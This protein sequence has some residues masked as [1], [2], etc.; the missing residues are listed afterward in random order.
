VVP[1]SERQSLLPY[2]WASKRD[3]RSGRLAFEIKRSSRPTERLDVGH[4]AGVPRRADCDGALRTCHKRGG[5]VD[6][7]RPLTTRSTLMVA[8]VPLDAWSAIIHRVN[9]GDDESLRHLIEQ[10]IPNVTVVPVKG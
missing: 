7:G 1:V 6:G 5:G 10:T 8:C 9:S 4:S 2:S 3:R